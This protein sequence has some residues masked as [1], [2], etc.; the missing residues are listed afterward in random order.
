MIRK[1]LIPL[2]AAA[3]VLFAV[4]TAVQS[5]RPVAPA[6]PVTDPP[7]PAFSGKISGSGIIEASSRNISIGSHVPGI[8]SRVLVKVGDR[9]KPG[10]PLFVLDDRRQKAEL[11]V[12][13]EALAGAQ[14][15]LRRLKEAP[16]KEELP[17]ARA[18]VKEAEAVLA[19]AKAQLDFVEGLKGQGAVS[20]EDETRRR[21]AF[22]R[23]EAALERAKAELALLEAG[24]WKADM[25]VAEA[26]VALR[27][28]EAEAARVELERLTVTAP[29]AGE[30]LQV[31][32]R[33]GEFA[34]AG[35][36]QQPLVLLGSI[37][38]MHVR[39]DI[40]ENDAWRFSPDA[41]AVAYLRGHADFKTDLTFQYVE[42][43]VVPKRSLTGE[44]TERV[45]TRVLQV[46]YSFSA[47]D[48][49]VYPG[50]LVDVY[51]EDKTSAAGSDKTSRSRPA[52]SGKE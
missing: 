6:L 36:N 42:K 35:I 48:F 11:A 14:A 33:P 25:E 12:R 2:L 29:V 34:Q 20:R 17:G 31:N 45:D 1:Y 9:V 26:E 46:I 49:S 51:I 8:V 15:R 32:V 24:A 43:Y 37:D 50:Q 18:R 38:V 16:R 40:D 13:M 47:R 28:A 7:E 23:A 22:E 52:P 4:W 10:E 39:V 19:D 27:R 21:Y 3:G 5:A 30:V 41:R 44:S